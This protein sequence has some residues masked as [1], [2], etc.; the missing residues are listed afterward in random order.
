M[1]T[2]LLG[3]W[4]EARAADYLRTKGYKIIGSG[5]RTRYGEIDLIAEDRKHIVFVEVKLRKTDKFANASEFV[6]SLKQ[7]RL[8]LTA[9][10]WLT[11]ND[12]DKQLRFDVVEI[13]APDGA[14]TRESG[15]N[16]IE[17]A[18]GED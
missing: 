17:N 5:Y 6:D 10:M 13:Y 7:E 16:H 14:G 15:I 1:N 18:F 11:Q 12:T 2:K 3:K 4:G 8:I 9:K